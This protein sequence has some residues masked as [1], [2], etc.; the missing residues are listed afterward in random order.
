[1]LELIRPIRP[2][3]VTDEALKRLVEI[4]RKPVD[5]VPNMEPIPILIDE[6]KN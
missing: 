1:M 6:K 2:D 4:S 3:I 5:L